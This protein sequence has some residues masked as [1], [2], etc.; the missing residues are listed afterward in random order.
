MSWLEVLLV[1]K[2]KGRSWRPIIY[3]AHQSGNHYDP[4]ARY[5]PTLGLLNECVYAWCHLVSFRRFK[6]QLVIGKPHCTFIE[7][8]LTIPLD[9]IFMM[10]YL[11]WHKLVPDLIHFFSWWRM[12][13]L[14]QGQPFR[15]DFWRPSIR[16]L[17]YFSL[18]ALTFVTAFEWYYFSLRSRWRAP[19]SPPPFK[20]FLSLSHVSYSLFLLIIQPRS[21][22][23][24]HVSKMRAPRIQAL[25]SSF[26]SLHLRLVSAY[27][28]PTSPE[29]TGSIRWDLMSFH[30]SIW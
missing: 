15:R 29:F 7:Y 22:W 1:W 9:L 24:W 10:F 25:R 20:S 12:Q 21:I 5:Y 6:A 30:T 26:E 4:A 16:H 23:N 14:L 11:L 28:L 19:T 18:L 27:P 2:T 8:L 3:F 13:A 17:P